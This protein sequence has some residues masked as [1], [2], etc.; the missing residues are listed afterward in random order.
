M[1]RIRILRPPRHRFLARKPCLRFRLRWEGWYSVPR[2]A[3]RTWSWKRGF[4][5]WGGVYTLLVRRENIGET[6]I[7]GWEFKTNSRFVALNIGRGG[8]R[9]TVLSS[10]SG[11]RGI[12]QK[13]KKERQEEIRHTSR[14]SRLHHV[15]LMTLMSEDSPTALLF[16][17]HF[18]L[19]V[20]SPIISVNSFCQQLVLC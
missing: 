15:V 18:W 10:V 6:W 8:G 3:K 20:E 5:V 12:S 7:F 4:I 16:I 13:K 2:A 19:D 9:R 14:K 17:N 11:I 1:R